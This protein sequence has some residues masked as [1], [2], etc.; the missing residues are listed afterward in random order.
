MTAYF[1]S[2]AND[3]KERRLAKANRKRITGSK[4]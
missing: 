4:E 2:A 3:P 1:M